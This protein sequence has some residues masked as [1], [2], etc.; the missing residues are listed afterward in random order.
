M[1]KSIF[2]EMVGKFNRTITLRMRLEP[3]TFDKNHKMQFG[4]LED[5]KIVSETKKMNQLFY[6][7]SQILELLT[8]SKNEYM[9]K[10]EIKYT[11]YNYLKQLIF[12]AV[13]WDKCQTSIYTAYYGSDNRDK[14]F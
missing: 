6:N 1:E 3:V 9:E 8:T 10:H 5:L 2:S 4:K 14:T 12:D 13:N 7:E 11:R